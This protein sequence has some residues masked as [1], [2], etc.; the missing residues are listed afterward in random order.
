M[1]KEI[2][3][4]IFEKNNQVFSQATG[5]VFGDVGFGIG[6][7]MITLAV[8][9]SPYAT[10]LFIPAAYVIFSRHGIKLDI[11]RG[12]IMEF[13]RHF[14]IFES[15]KWKTNLLYREIVI[16]G[17]TETIA[18]NFGIARAGNFS[19]SKIYVALMDKYHY[20]RLEIYSTENMPDARKIAALISEKTG[21][22]V[23]EFS[24]KRISGK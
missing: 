3:E 6:L 19:S 4:D 20:K 16:L 15:G 22:P 24:P 13:T 14:G 17:G 18:A 10:F 23:V 5:R 2:L 12:K 1:S 7:G 8:V 11:H 9:Y 21:F